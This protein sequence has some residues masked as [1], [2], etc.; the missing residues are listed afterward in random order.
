MAKLISRSALIRPILLILAVLVTLAMLRLGVWQLDRAQQ[1]SVLVEQR[2]AVSNDKQVDLDQLILEQG[3]AG[4]TDQ[5]YRP[6]SLQGGYTNDAPLFVDSK[7][8]N[9]RVGYDVYNVFKTI[10]GHLVLIN[11]GWI[12][13]GVSRDILPD[14][15]KPKLDTPL[16]GRLNVLAA[17]PPM[18]DDR[19][20]VQTGS[21]WQYLPLKDLTAQYGQN[22]APMVVELAPELE[23]PGLTIQWTGADD[24]GVAM[25][26]GYAFQWFSMALAFVIAC[27]VLLIKSLGRPND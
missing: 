22:I 12:Y 26:K 13:V 7:V 11:R 8:Q 5:R 14:V 16:Y 18:W 10:S 20:S 3:V 24:S 25:H 6:V 19:Y 23:A 9:N 27:L 15:P 1:K 4:L 21:V 17:P 2:I